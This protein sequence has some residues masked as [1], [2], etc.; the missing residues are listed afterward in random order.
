[1]ASRWVPLISDM[2]PMRV[3]PSGEIEGCDSSAGWVVSRVATPPSTPTRHRSP[4]AAKTIERA[5]VASDIGITPQS[6]G[7]LIRLPIPPLSEERP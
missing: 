3:V 7:K 5:I 2:D 1:M 4:S 6:D